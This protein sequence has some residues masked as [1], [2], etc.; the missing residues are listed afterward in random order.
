MERHIVPVILYGVDHRKAFEIELVARGPSVPFKVIVNNYAVWQQ[1]QDNLADL[2]TGDSRS[3]F[4]R[5][6]ALTM[7]RTHVDRI[8]RAEAV[9]AVGVVFRL[10]DLDPLADTR[11]L[12]QHIYSIRNSVCL[13]RTALQDS[14]LLVTA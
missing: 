14:Y 9:A 6:Q 2:L 3:L 13:G 11:E 8:R 10:A 4:T 12:S 1:H 7:A 5:K